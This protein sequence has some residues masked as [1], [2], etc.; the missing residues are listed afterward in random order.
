MSLSLIIKYSFFKKYLLLI[1]LTLLIVI[2]F[3]VVAVLVIISVSGMPSLFIANALFFFSIISSW[4]SG[5]CI[6]FLLL[7]RIFFSSSYNL[8]ISVKILFKLTLTLIPFV[9]ICSFG[10]VNVSI[11][12]AIVILYFIKLTIL[13]INLWI[14]ICLLM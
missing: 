7:S 4:I 12:S 14:K 11:N 13:L 3:G 9:C 8:L 2:W 5:S 6:I 1:S 10:D